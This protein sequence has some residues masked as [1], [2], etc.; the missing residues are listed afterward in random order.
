MPRQTT[1][2]ATDKQE[3]ILRV[4][5]QLFAK[6]GYDTTT[7]RMISREAGISLGLL[8]NYFDGK[9]AVLKEIVR[10][11]LVDLEIVYRI[12]ADGTPPDRLAALL[13][14]V[15]R[16][17]GRNLPFHRLFAA[18]RA[19]GGVQR[20]LGEELQRF[21]RQVLQRLGGL[22]AE[23]GS[24]DPDA[25]ALLLSAIIDGCC[26]RYTR[27]PGQFAFETLHRRVLAHFTAA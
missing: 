3:Q 6:H 8:Y 19:Q 11:N 27:N 20:A 4:S 17:T 9:N 15:F 12:P 23:L 14:R 18:L 1:S 10:R 25:D 26:D 24:P 7:I 2:S 22:L 21:D 5:L 16:H 13:E